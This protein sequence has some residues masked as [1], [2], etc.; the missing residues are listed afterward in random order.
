[1]EEFLDAE[2]EASQM[3]AATMTEPEEEEAKEPL[4]RRSRS[5]VAKLS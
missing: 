3:E 4:V 5:T 1:M 2:S